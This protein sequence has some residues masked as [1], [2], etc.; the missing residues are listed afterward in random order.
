MSYL[1][2][3]EPFQLSAIDGLLISNDGMTFVMSDAGRG[4]SA[5]S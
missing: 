3:G 2:S 5:H 1:N 4:L